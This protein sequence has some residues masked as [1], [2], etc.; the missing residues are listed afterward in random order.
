MNEL[1]DIAEKL[2]DTEATIREVKKAI[3][4]GPPTP[5]IIATLETLE[6]RQGDLEARFAEAAAEH[7]LDVCS[8]RLFPDQKEGGKPR[9]TTQ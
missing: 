5:S 2:Q 8:Y 3:A 9:F 6:K 7:H 1:L 4:Q